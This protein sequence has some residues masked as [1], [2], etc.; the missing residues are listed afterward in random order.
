[1]ELS[2][3]RTRIARYLQDTAAVTWNDDE[4]DDG[5]RFALREFSEYAPLHAE[6]LITCPA[7]GREIALDSIDGLFGI[8]KVWWPYDS[9]AEAWPPNQVVGWQLLWDDA[10][11][12][13]F[14]SKLAGGEPQLD[15]EIRIWY[16]KRHTVNGLDGQVVTTIIPNHEEMIVIGAAGYASQSKALS[17]G[18]SIDR[19]RLDTWGYRRISDFRRHLSRLDNQETRSGEPW[20]GGWRLDK[21]DN[22]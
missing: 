3:Y 9:T 11:P 13:L 6:T 8:T 19:D 16:I 12:V 1:M 5:L 10:R 21:W 4:L 15:D 22:Q 14:F 17:L 20:G 2:E 7:A 18:L